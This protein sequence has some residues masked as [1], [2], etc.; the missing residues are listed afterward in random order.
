M[1]GMICCGIM[2]VDNK[3]QLLILDSAR[4][5]YSPEKL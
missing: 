1:C 4:S 3:L 2:P 5:I